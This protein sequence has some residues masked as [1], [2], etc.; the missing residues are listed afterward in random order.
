MNL[1]RLGQASA[2]ERIATGLQINRAADNPAGLVI[3]EVLRSQLGSTTQAIE[4]TQFAANMVATAEGGLLEINSLLADVRARAVGAMNTGGSTPEMQAA[5]QMSIDMALQAINRIAETTRFGSSQLLN[6]AAAFATNNVAPQFA[7]IRIMSATLPAG[8]A[9]ATIDVNVTAAAQRATAG[10][11]IAPVQAAASTIRIRGANG[12]TELSFAAGATQAEV[13]AAIND[14]TSN[15][16]VEAVGGQ[17]RST[18]YGSAASVEFTV[19]QGSFSGITPGYYTGTDVQG[20]VEGLPAQGLGNQLN[21]TSTGLTAQF[22]LDAGTGPGTYTFDIV[23]GGLNFQLGTEA[24]AANQ[25]R[26]GIE[27][28]TASRLG[29]PGSVGNLASIGSGAA[30]NVLANPGTA[31]QIIDSAVNQVSMTRGQLGAVAQQQLQ[32]NISTLRVAFE[33]LS[34]SQSYI[35]DADVAQ[36]AANVQRSGILLEAAIR[37]LRSANITQGGVL[38]LL[39]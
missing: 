14:T 17:I 10:G 16:G 30:N 34:A 7:D 27:S 19:L 35:R 29:L 33:N 28:M 24:G 37:A 25:L 5:N 3:S 20:T 4:N 39:G 2:L 23:S 8:G 6:G 1:A 15:T 18:D 22:Q 13:M 9:P 36:E 12:S 31:L 32:P 21:I 38:R 11:L 26:V